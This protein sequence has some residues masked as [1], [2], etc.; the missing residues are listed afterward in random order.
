VEDLSERYLGWIWEI[1]VRSD[2]V[3][4]GYTACADE[5]KAERSAGKTMSDIFCERLLRFPHFQPLVEEA[6]DLS[7]RV[8]S[9][10]CRV[11][12][13]STGPNWIMVGEAASMVDPMTANGVTAAL[14]HAAEASDLILGSLGRDALRRLPRWLYS[15]RVR[16][17]GL[18]FN[19]GIERLIYDNCIRRRSGVLRSGD[20]YTKFAWS[21]NAVYS[22]SKPRGLAGTLAFTSTLTVLRGG[23]WTMTQWFRRAPR[24]R[25]FDRRRLRLRPA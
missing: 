8:T 7:P 9:Y 16:Q 22:R 10:R 11:Y 21:M 20:L 2:L 19:S 5:I 15:V 6:G 1:P 3:S 4:V 13:R 12:R 17:F 18:F 25:S 24:L 23:A 14:R